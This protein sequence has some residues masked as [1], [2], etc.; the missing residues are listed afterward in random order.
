M[1]PRETR[2]RVLRAL[3]RG[4]LYIGALPLIVNAAPAQVEAA[5]RELKRQGRVSRDIHGTVTRAA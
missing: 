5:V 2:E 3:E 4:P 1:T